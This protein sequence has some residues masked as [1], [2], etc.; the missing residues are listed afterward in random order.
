MERRF[1]RT[2]LYT[3]SAAATLLLVAS[4]SAAEQTV[5]PLLRDFIGLNGHTVQFKPDLYQPTARLVRDYHPVQWDLGTNTT[6][7]APFPFAK[8]RVDWSAVYGLWRE[9]EWTI[10]VS[11]MFESIRRTNWADID[12]DAKAYG[13]SF[14]REFG[15]SG[16]R[17]LV[18]SIEIG[19]EPGDWSDADYTR[20]FR[21]MA[22][23]AT[24]TPRVSRSGSRNLATTAAL[25]RRRRAATLPNGLA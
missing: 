16:A 2:F 7:V 24:R 20:M 25:S 6:A 22:E 11:L 1:R 8:N 23:G 15:P 9:K 10:D 4:S 18:E 13:R 21:A 5:R 12:R 19:N 17:R 14:A 3:I